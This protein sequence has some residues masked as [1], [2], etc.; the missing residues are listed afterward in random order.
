[1]MIRIC[2]H[3]REVVAE[4][5]KEI[6]KKRRNLYFTRYDFTA[7][8]FNVSYMGGAYSTRDGGE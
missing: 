6:H 4:T 2:E 1:M 3:K 7:I 5:W 8:K